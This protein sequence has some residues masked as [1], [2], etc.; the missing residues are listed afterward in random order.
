MRLPQVDEGLF[1]ALLPQTVWLGPT[2]YIFTLENALVCEC[3]HNYKEILIRLI[4]SEIFSNMYFYIFASLSDKK[5]SRAE[6]E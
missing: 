3:F 2:L 1:L 5:N 4:L 6:R